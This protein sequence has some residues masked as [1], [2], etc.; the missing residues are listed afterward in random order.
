[1]IYAR[2]VIK[3]YTQKAGFVPFISTALRDGGLGKRVKLLL[4]VS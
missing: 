3:K 1:M 2:I 4:C